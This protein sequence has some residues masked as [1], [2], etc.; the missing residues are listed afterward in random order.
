MGHSKIGLY[1]PLLAVQIYLIL[2]QNAKVE[3]E[4][5]R[6]GPRRVIKKLYEACS[7]FKSVF[8]EVSSLPSCSQRRLT[9]RKRNAEK[10]EILTLTTI[11]NMLIDEKKKKKKAKEARK[12]T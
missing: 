5:G 4:T 8:L 10:S 2:D 9:N 6:Q 3:E 7:S 11:K 1:G 12:A